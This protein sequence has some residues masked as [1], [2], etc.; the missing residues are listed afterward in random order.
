[1]INR[2][3]VGVAAVLSVASAV[4]PHLRGLAVGFLFNI[5]FFSYLT[6]RMLNRKRLRYIRPAR[7]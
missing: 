1:M 6:L 4:L 2:L 3:A 7:R 5:I